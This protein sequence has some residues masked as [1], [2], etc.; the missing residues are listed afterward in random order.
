M[1]DIEELRDVSYEIAQMR[2]AE[3]F[4]ALCIIPPAYNGVVKPVSVTNIHLIPGSIEPPLHKAELTNTEIP[5]ELASACVKRC[6]DYMTRT[7]PIF[8]NDSA[9][10]LASVVINATHE[11]HQDPTND[12]EFE[13][14]GVLAVCLTSAGPFAYGFTSKRF[15]SAF[16]KHDPMTT[17]PSVEDI[18]DEALRLYYALESEHKE[19]LPPYEVWKTLGLASLKVSPDAIQKHDGA[20]AISNMLV[21]PSTITHPVFNSELF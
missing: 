7:Q 5:L 8:N 21:L 19:G 4:E 13:T 15:I 3:N 10:S 16:M 17:L 12:R 9:R 20:I 1:P 6:T 14:I 11:L 18:P 2:D